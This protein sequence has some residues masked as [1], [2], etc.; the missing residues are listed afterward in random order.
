MSSLARYMLKLGKNVLGYDLTATELTDRLISEG[1]KISFQDNAEKVTGLSLDP[2]N[3]LVVRTPA[4]PKQ[5]NILTFF[6]KSKF[7]VVKRAELLGEITRDTLCLAV[8]G[9]HGK[10]TTSAILG[11]LMASCDQPVTA[12]LGGIAENYQSNFIYRGDKIAVVE[13]DEYDRSFL[14]LKPDIACVTSMD[15]DHLDIYGDSLQ[16]EEGFKMFAGLLSEPD[17]LIVQKG[18]D[19]PGRTVSVSEKADFYAGNIR[20]ANGKYRFDFYGPQVV[21]RDLEFIMPGLHNL[22]NAVTALGMAITAGTPTHCLPKALKTFKGIARR[23]SYRI[24]R[25]DLVLIDDYAH[26]P[27]ELEALYQA[28][29]ERY[30]RDKKLIVFQ[31]HLY[32]RTRDFAQGFASS[33]ARFDEVLLLEIYPARELAISGVTSSWLLDQ[34]PNENKA[35]VAKADLTSRLA[36]SNCRIK[37]IVGAGDI[38][39]E[40]EHITKHLSNAN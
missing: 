7:E 24:D 31:P 5:N 16:I 6:N 39:M 20:I 33:L 36:G 11:H 8:A 18:L 15:A 4:I 14:T 9:T 37:C 23:F 10:T 32:S 21:L 38:G 19:L 26:H 13:A 3:T 22:Q 17:N 25:D 29:Q 34:I 12:F 2:N 28:L 40:V 35:V 30:P 1:A 27:S